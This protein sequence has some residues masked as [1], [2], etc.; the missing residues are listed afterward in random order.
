MTAAVIDPSSADGELHYADFVQY[1]PHAPTAL[2]IKECARLAVL[3]RYRCSG[4]ILDVGCGDGVFARIAFSDQEVWGIDIDAKE[5]RWA[6]A[7]RAYQQIILGDITRAKLPES[8]FATCIA[9]CSLE[10]VP[11]I[12][13]ALNTIC[14]SLSP[15]ARAYLFVPQRDWAGQL[16]SV[17]TLRRLGAPALADKLQNG[18]DNFFKHHHLYD[19]AGWRQVLAKT[20]FEVESIEP[21]LTTATTEAFEAFLLPSIAGWANKKLTTRWTNFPRVRRLFAPLAFSLA[22]AAIAT[23]GPAPTGEFLIVARRPAAHG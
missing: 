19:E 11:G 7:S 8:F 4:P 13:D 12:E 22:K 9:N 21:V 5:G 16:R 10:H 18:V 2:C 6:Q 1:Y 14:R 17:R 20:P 23:G 3:R 15:G